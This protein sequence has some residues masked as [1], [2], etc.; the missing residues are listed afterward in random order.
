MRHFTGLEALC[1]KCGVL[2]QRLPWQ[3]VCD[4]CGG[5]AMPRSDSTVTVAPSWHWCSTCQRVEPVGSQYHRVGR[6][7]RPRAGR[8]A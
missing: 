6:H 4:S 3:E 2:W 1:P 5:E 8:T 7:R